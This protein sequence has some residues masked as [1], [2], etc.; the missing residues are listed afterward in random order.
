MRRTLVL[1]VLGLTPDLVGEHTPHLAALPAAVHA[2]SQKL[3]ILEELPRSRGFSIVGGMAVAFVILQLVP[4]SPSTSAH[5]NR[6][7]RV[8]PSVF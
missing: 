1:N 4:Q 7:R 6:P 3:R 8:D 5:S 2:F